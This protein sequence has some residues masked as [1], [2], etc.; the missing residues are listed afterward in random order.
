MTNE[1]AQK[2]RIDTLLF[3]LDRIKKEYKELKDSIPNPS[4]SR[5]EVI[6]I[7][8]EIIK[9]FELLK[10]SPLGKNPLSKKSE[11]FNEGLEQSI[12]II[13]KGRD[14]KKT[15]TFWPPNQEY[16]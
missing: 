15:S 14:N 8:N 9:D 3:E 12:W 5:N 11:G 10:A 4:F 2:I 7:L 16:R 13:E 1:D 6:R